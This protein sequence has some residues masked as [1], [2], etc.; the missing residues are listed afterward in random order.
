MKNHPCLTHFCHRLKSGFSL[1][2]PWPNQSPSPHI[3]PYTT[4]S[5]TISTTIGTDSEAFLDPCL[6]VEPRVSCT[7]LSCPPQESPLKKVYYLPKTQ[8]LKFTITT[9]SHLHLPFST[10]S[11]APPQP[12]FKICIL[13]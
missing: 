9:A 3:Y 12:T 1:I 2:S 7:P 6:L 11:T 10:S 4:L 8:T 13:L 5:N